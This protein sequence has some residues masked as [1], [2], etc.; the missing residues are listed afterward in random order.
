MW[1]RCGSNTPSWSD[2]PL[3]EAKLGRS[4]LVLSR[5]VQRPDHFS[6]LFRDWSIYISIRNFVVI[7]NNSFSLSS[8]RPCDLNLFSVKGLP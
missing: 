2:M 1:P 5:A 3:G 7:F 6:I 8:E 4:S